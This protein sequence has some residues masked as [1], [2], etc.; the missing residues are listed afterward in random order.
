MN[1]SFSCKICS[2]LSDHLE[3]ARQHKGSSSVEGYV[4]SEA[5]R[6]ARF[7]RPPASLQA[8]TR[9]VLITAISTQD[10]LGQ[11]MSIATWRPPLMTSMEVR[12]SQ[13]RSTTTLHR[14]ADAPI[15]GVSNHGGRTGGLPAKKE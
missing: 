12:Y 10:P 14:Y 8:N 4:D 11:I 7:E 5:S 6:P 2:V 3:I 1:I 13:Y 15:G 9:F